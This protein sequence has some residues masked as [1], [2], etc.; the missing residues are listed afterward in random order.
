MF[1][2]STIGV[3]AEQ[4]HGGMHMWEKEGEGGDPEVSQLLPWTESRP[5][6]GGELVVVVSHVPHKPEQVPDGGARV[7]PPFP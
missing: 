3:S 5:H 6:L 4:L 7:A 2:S 1:D